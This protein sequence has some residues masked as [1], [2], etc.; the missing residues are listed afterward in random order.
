MFIISDNKLLRFKIAI[1]NMS[2]IIK[3]IPDHVIPDI[4][5]DFSVVEV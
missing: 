4:F 2:V 3:Y 5:D 1:K